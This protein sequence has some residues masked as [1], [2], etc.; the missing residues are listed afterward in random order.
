VKKKKPAKTKMAEKT[1]EDE[2]K[3]KLYQVSSGEKV[4]L[5]KEQ[6]HIILTS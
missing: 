4:H 1:I 6:L 2:P 5:T 3:K